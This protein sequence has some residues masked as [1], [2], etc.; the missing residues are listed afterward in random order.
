M[1]P[2]SQGI[3]ALMMLNIME[4]F[5]IEDPGSADAWHLKIEAQKLAYQDLRAFNADP[6]AVKVPTKGMLSKT[7]ATERAKL[8]D[9][10]KATCSISAPSRNSNLRLRS[11]NLPIPIRDFSAKL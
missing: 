9:P 3:A 6:R 2:S 8:I 11:P 4:K 5:R 7:Y 10:S 1:P